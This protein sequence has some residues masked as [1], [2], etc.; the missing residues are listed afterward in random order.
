ME[1]IC[2]TQSLRLQMQEATTGLFLLV[3]LLIQDKGLLQL[4]PRLEVL[5]E[6]FALLQ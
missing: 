2:R 3:Q 5:P 1:V 4:S 6:M